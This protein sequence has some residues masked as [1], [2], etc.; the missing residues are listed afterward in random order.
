MDGRILTLP[1]ALRHRGEEQVLT[2]K[3]N[4]LWGYTSFYSVCIVGLDQSR[5][6]TVT[7]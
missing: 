1:P 2:V 3:L 7:Q 5:Y 4:E 6:N